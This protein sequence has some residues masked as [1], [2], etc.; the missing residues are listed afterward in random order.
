MK[1]NKILEKQK[2]YI[3]RKINIGMDT[4]I[5]TLSTIT[6]ILNRNNL[7]MGGNNKNNTKPRLNKKNINNK[8]LE[9]I[10]KKLDI[11]NFNR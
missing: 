10:F 2:R 3:N 5:A 4:K 7:I 11:P 1:C 8:K 9:K 6:S